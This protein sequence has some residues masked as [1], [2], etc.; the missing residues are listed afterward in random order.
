MIAGESLGVNASVYTRTPSFYLVVEMDTSSY[1]SQQHIPREYNV[2]AYMISGEAKFGGGGDGDG[3]LATPHSLIITERDGDTIEVRTLSSSSAKFALIGGQP[4]NEPVH[5]YGP[6]V[7]N[8]DD[9]LK[10]A[11]QDYRVCV[12]VCMCVC[13]IVIADMHVCMDIVG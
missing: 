4:L 6:F 8:T 3:V 10:Q 5:Q 2:F 12:C 9:E 1:F 11:I 7:M 13:I